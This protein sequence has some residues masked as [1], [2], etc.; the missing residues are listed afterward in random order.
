MTEKEISVRQKVEA[1]SEQEP[2]RPGRVFLPEVDIFESAD[3][4]YLMA[5][6]PGVAPG[7]VDIDLK[8]GVLTLS[9][10]AVE[11]TGVRER[12]IRAEYETGHYRRQ[13]SLSQL[14]DQSKI[15]ARMKDGVLE[16]RLPKIE[17]AQPRKIEVSA[18]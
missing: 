4:L 5:D 2:T 12:A 8:E 13:F 14:I 17:R 16:L 1:P 3:S 10:E 9:A 11:P 15:E 18:A 6:L 7:K